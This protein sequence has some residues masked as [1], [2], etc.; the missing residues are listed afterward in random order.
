MKITQIAT[1]R[2]VT[3]F[4]FFTAIIL[5]GIVSLREL[6]VDLLPDISYPRLSVVTKYSGVAPEEIETLITADLEAAVSRI[7]GMRR[8]ES[9]SKEGVSYM[10]LEFAWGTDMDFAMLHTRE[11][12]DSVRDDL[13]EDA[14]EPTIIPL[15]PQS[16]PILTLS[17]SGN[18]SLL[19]LK[20]FSEELIKP[21]L[22]QI[23]GIG[24][25]EIAGGVEREIHVEVNPDYLALYDLSI[26][27]ISERIDAFNSNLEGG[28]IRKG[29]F[30]YSLRVVGEFEDLDEIGEISLK[31]TATRGVIKLK[32]VAQIKDSIKEREGIT[33]L[34]SQESI[35]ILVRKESGANTVK[36]SQIARNVLEEIRNENSGIDILTVSEQA[37]YI[38][39]AI[40]SVLNSI[41]IGGILA[42]LVLFVFLQD[43]K[44]P[45]IIAVV[46]PISIIATFNLLFF[47]DI[48]L[49]IMSLGG[50]ALGVG[51][52]VDNSIVVSESIFR[53]RSLGK[54]L[55]EAAVVG[56]KEVGMAVTASTLTTISVFLP[57]IYVHGVAGQLFKDQALTVTFALISSL[58]VSLTLLPTLSSR[59]I[60]P[61]DFG[62][63]KKSSENEDE[64][65]EIQSKSALRFLLLPFK[66]IRWLLYNIPKGIFIGLSFIFSFFAQLFLLI[67]HYI[68]LPFRP[69][70]QAIFKGYNALY[71]GF[72]K[73]YHR[74][75]IWALDNKMAVVA[76]SCIFLVITALAAAQIPRE[77]LPK[78]E[79]NAFE[80]HMKTPV[81]YSL[82]QTGELV[83][84]LEEW[85]SDQGSITAYFSQIGIVSGM[86]ALNPDVS[87]NSAKLYI[88]AENPSKVEMLIEALRGQLRGFPG[89]SFSILKEQSTLTEFL[90]FTTAEVGLKIK[91]EDLNR[92]ALLSA[93]LVKNL[94][95]IP[96]ITDV[97]TNLGEGKPEFLIQINKAALEKYDI[98]P[99]TIGSFLVDAVR[100]RKAT[101]FKELD[102]KYDVR[103]RMEE[104]TRENIDSILDEQISHRGTLIP[105]R[106]LV[107]YDI[108]RGP[109]EIRRENQQREVVVTANLKGQK[110]SQVVPAINDKIADLEL[111]QGYR[112]VFSGEQ[113]EMAKSFQS[114]IFAFS[115]AVLLVYMIMAAQFESLKHPFLILFTLPM[116][117]TG[118]V[119]ALLIT[120][121]TLNVI[122]IIGMVVL[123]GIVVND[124]IVKIDFT[125]QLRRKGHT[126]REAI[127][128]ASRI[129]LRP[130]LMT[131][132]TTTLGL[133]PMS[134]G[135]GRGS[136]LQQPLA[137]SVIGGLLLATFLT[138][139]LIPMAY[140]VAEKKKP[141]FES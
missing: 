53:H 140:E 128:E 8:V 11:K 44:T 25:A 13:P 85:L 131:T 93:Q 82:E 113:E 139:I 141:S 108:V 61:V 74:V 104:E 38:E 49:N 101:Q 120:G 89:L 100:G 24:S 54:S 98:S 56:T 63:E 107:S 18:R 16:K 2:P 68:G 134:L 78:P 73:R 40:S 36:V 105:L 87:L 22:E 80:V 132:V 110:I 109:R 19:E 97:S 103:V 102:K 91:G 136:E 81:D 76:G 37:K 62:S 118:A 59:Q 51:M 34:N 69:L 10:T 9:V 83:A 41:I 114:L 58:L 55:S 129:R 14:E 50:L 23:E 42:F 48:T 27:K 138:L 137:I 29:R 127:M 5:L 1:R 57:V 20:E 84:V 92:L 130:I 117:L 95:D 124:A 28:T 4:M 75:L 64:P 17:V 72:E 106:E 88:E 96:G 133:F 79:S 26:K 71:Q 52:L 112:V 125:N 66:G 39:N 35:G 121:Q 33:R 123:A 70:I 111:P 31:T 116:G 86:E 30:K 7:P 94:K 21:R 6:S 47:R 32:D 3:T 119:W 115:L 122:S 45:L 90:A 43:I 77:L 67:F 135:L 65:E 46:I 60:K 15:D 12:L 126:V 99:G